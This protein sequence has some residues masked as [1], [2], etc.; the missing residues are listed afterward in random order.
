MAVK[1]PSIKESQSRDMRT[2]RRL[3]GLSVTV[4]ILAAVVLLVVFNVLAGKKSYRKDVETLGHYALSKTAGQIVDGVKQPTR[5]TTIYTSTKDDRKADQYLPRLRDL[6]DEMHRR[7]DNITVINASSDRQKADVLARLRQQLEQVA[8]RD[9]EVIESYD[10]FVQ[11]Q[12]KQFDK[13]AEWWNS[14]PAEGYL[15]QFGAA[16]RVQSF[17]MQMKDQLSKDARTLQTDTTSGLPNYPD[18]I[19]NVREKLTDM[20]KSLQSINELIS[21]LAELPA[22]AASEKDSLIE[23]CGAVD[24]ELVLCAAL[25]AA[26][27][28][29]ADNLQAV[30]QAA[31]KAALA[32]RKAA[33]LLLKFGKDSM[34]EAVPSWD[35]GGQQP[36]P[37]CYAIIFEE[38]RQIAESAAVTAQKDPNSSDQD[39]LALQ[40]ARLNQIKNYLG[41]IQEQS[42]TAQ[43]SLVQMLAAVSRVDPT[44][45]QLFD[46]FKKGEELAGLLKPIE[47]LLEKSKESVRATGEDVPEQLSDKLTK[48]QDV[49]GHI[50]DENIVLIESGDSAAVVAFDDVWPVL[51]RQQAEPL[52]ENQ[53]PQRTF[54]GDQAVSSKLLAMT[55]DPLA[56][57]VLVHFDDPRMRQMQQMRRMS[58]DFGDPMPLSEI[59]TLRAT[60]EKANLIVSEWNLAMSPTPPDPKPLRAG[61]A[62]TNPSTMPAE[63]FRPQVLLVMPPPLSP[64]SLDAPEEMPGQM[65]GAFSRKHIDLLRDAIEGRAGRPAIPAIFMASWLP[66]SMQRDPYSGRMFVTTFN[67]HYADYLKDQWGLDVRTGMRVFQGEASLNKP[68]EFELPVLRIG[69][70][71]LADFTDHPAGRPLRDRRYYWLHVC[72][73]LPVKDSACGAA[74]TPILQITPGSRDTWAVAEP[75]NVFQKVS[76]DELYKPSADNGDIFSTK[77]KPLAVAAQATRKIGEQE[78]SVIALGLAQ[79]YQ[80]DFLTSR[81]RKVKAGSR[82]ASLESEP[83][84]LGDVDLVI[85]SVYY[86]SGQD[87]YIGA[88]PQIIKPISM[89]GPDTLATVKWAFGLAW[90]ALILAVGLVVMVIR[91]R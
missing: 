7:N 61:V 56:E 74:F 63:K 4:S 50:A 22:K 29:P 32:A 91:K 5:I 45:Q 82:D 36:L 39:R 35:V 57:V 38:A 80:N 62:A 90:P 49:I 3:A 34:A 89:T 33:N 84:P 26:E 1:Q 78:V 16:K 20:Q 67:Y 13:A 27:G 41:Q 9:R 60:L 76:N 58:G 83:P 54:N 40:K 70:M 46:S 43:Q 28:Q 75:I 52:K 53:P 68:G 18:T 11:T 69:F 86:L 79:S 55:V 65:P 77:D 48:W 51:S 24:K 85:N 88:G 19:K 37:N 17:L 44:T 25:A 8:A 12:S 72:P 81:V 73:V 59:S 71:P 6:L 10:L 64:P 31:L 30:N 2:S 47:A 21:S 66:P 23:A 15:S 42:K 87:K 14:Y